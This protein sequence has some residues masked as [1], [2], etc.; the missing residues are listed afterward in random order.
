M[1]EKII[2]G[3]LQKIIDDSSSNV[4]ELQLVYDF[5][6]RRCNEARV[7]ERL[8]EIYVDKEKL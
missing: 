1:N 4:D 2:L 6:E 5:L 3:I 8:L 7:A